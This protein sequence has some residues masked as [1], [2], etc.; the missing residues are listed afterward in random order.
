MSER[1]GTE[2]RAVGHLETKV[3]SLEVTIRKQSGEIKE[4]RSLLLGLL[5]DP[6]NNS[7]WE[8]VVRWVSI[9]VLL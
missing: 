2:R 1:V 8:R 3:Q 4:M 5:F 9:D 6:G 7:Q